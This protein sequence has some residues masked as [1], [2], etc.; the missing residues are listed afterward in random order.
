VTGEPVQFSSPLPADLAAAL[1][2]LGL[3]LPQVP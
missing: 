1:G 2:P 3:S